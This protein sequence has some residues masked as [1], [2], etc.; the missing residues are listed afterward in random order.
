MQTISWDD[1]I[2]LIDE[3]PYNIDFYQDF[4]AIYLNEHL[5]IDMSVASI[6]EFINK[7]KTDVGI[8]YAHSPT[9]LSATSYHSS[10][11]F[12]KALNK[13]SKKEKK[14]EE[15]W[16]KDKKKRAKNS[17]KLFAEIDSGEYFLKNRR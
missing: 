1:E 7:P 8:D 9:T 2:K 10:Q 17:A 15:K 14:A 6:I 11:E 4:S 16:K 12:K 3:I 13:F 5:I